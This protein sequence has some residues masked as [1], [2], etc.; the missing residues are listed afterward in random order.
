METDFNLARRARSWIVLYLLLAPLSLLTSAGCALTRSSWYPPSAASVNGILVDSPDYLA[1]AEAQYAAGAAAEV[2]GNPACIDHYYAAAVQSW[3]Y[4]VSTA[5]TP[6]D[7]AT[8]L[9]RS[10]VECFISSATRFC[11]LNPNQGV[12][13]SSGQI[14]PITYRGFVWSP[15]DF[16]FF[17]PVGTYS[18][19]HLTTRYVTGGVG[20]PYVVLTDNALGRPF[21]RRGQPFAATAVLAPTCITNANAPTNT[22]TLALYDPLRT[23]TTDT[24][25]PLARDLS[26]PFAYSNSLEGRT[27]IDDFLR[28]T[29]DEAEEG[30]HMREP[31]QPGKIP[32][33]FVHG[34]ASD[35]Q[36][37]SQLESDLQADPAILS[38][39]Q[40]WL[41]RYDTGEPFLSSAALLRRHLAA[42]RQ[43]YDPMRCDP[44]LSQMVLVSH[45]MGGLLAKLQ[46]TASGDTLWQAAATRPLA[47]IVTDPAARA[48]LASAF[49]FQPSP[50][51]TR[52][53]FIATPHRGSVYAVRMVGRVSSALVED[54]PQWRARHDQLIR[55]NPG[56]FR[57]EISRG[58]PTSVDLLEPDS[59]ILEATTRLCFRP[60]VHLHTILGDS[61][62]RPS[63]GRSDGVV[64]V[65]SARLAGVESELDVDAEHTEI[66][67]RPETSREV[68]AIL[69][70]HAA[71]SCALPV[72]P[73]VSW[74]MPAP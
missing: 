44:N 65:S 54:P 27:A 33:V 3:P 16:R 30:I 72:E 38:R 49:Y 31:F 18:S 22:F 21:I 1:A 10:S 37:W 69:A 71:I 58:I 61:E 47:T 66:Q 59:Q 34:L 12:Q 45:S 5:A 39:Y 48:D 19:Q 11:R 40:I 9:Y 56:A 7:R 43:T 52:V 63:E 42:V 29:R 23:R 24:G 2:I 46:V 70:R 60:D 17:L 8:E 35:P 28:P 14:V 53:V 51:V 55:D 20:V 67:R 64:A 50:D 62:W 25:L 73:E 15:P 6:G 13:L 32:V 68:M 57:E 36:T 4:H 41:F 26:A 74:T